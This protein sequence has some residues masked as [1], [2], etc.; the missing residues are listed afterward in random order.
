MNFVARQ[1]VPNLVVVPVSPSGTVCF[2]VYGAAHLLAD[3]SGYFPT[4]GDFASLSPSR[5]LEHRSGAKVGNG[6]HG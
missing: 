2:F 3:V 6:R 1:T 5:V 4:A